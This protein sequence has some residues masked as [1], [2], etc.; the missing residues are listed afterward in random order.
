MKLLT[1]AIREQ[2]LKNGRINADQLTAE[3]ADGSTTDFKPVVK[4]FT[5]AGAATWLLTE[6][7]PCE[8]IAF[9]LCCLGMGFP[10][11]GSVS[12]SELASVQTPFG[13]AVERDMYFKASKTL[14]EYA[15][16]ARQHGS[17]QA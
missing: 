14:S 8:D 11:L 17:I 9:G 13:P 1:K 2:L 15:A 5:P 12:L 3:D 4:L 10:E 6:L 7:D 16:E